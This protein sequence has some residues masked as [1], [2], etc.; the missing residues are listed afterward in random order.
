MATDEEN[1]VSQGSTELPDSVPAIESDNDFEFE[2]LD[3][4]VNALGVSAAWIVAGVCGSGSGG[5]GAK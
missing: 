4:D 1:T 3:A 2:N 5:S